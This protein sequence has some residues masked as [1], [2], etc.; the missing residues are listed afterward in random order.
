MEIVGK[1]FEDG[2]YY[3]SELIFAADIF[4]KVNDPLAER[5]KGRERPKLATIVLGT[6]KNDIHEFGK[7]IVATILSLQRDR[8]D[9]PGHRRGVRRL[10]HRH[11]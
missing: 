2:E 8:D 1:R 5:L 10:R 11:P 9:R 7:N 3:L 6:V 4:K